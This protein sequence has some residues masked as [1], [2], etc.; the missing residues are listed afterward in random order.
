MRGRFQRLPRM[1]VI[2]FPVV[3]A[4][5]IATGALQLE[6]L[7]R[8]DAFVYD[9]R[10]RIFMPRTLDER[11]VIVDLDEK[12]LAE[13]G[14]WPWSRNVM[15]RLVDTLFD[16]QKIAALA[17]DVVFAEADESSGLGKLQKLARDELRLQQGFKQ[18][19]QRL[20]PALDY[21]RLFAEALRGRPVVLGYYFTSDREGRKSGLLPEPVF[22]DADLQ[23]RRFEVTEWDGYGANIE[24]LA[25][26]APG[27]GFFNPVIDSDGVVRS[28]PLLARYDG[29]YYESM[30]L[31]LFRT[32]LGNAVVKPG[33]A[34]AG[35]YQHL[36]SVRLER[37]DDSFEIP[38]DRQ[39]AAWVPF[40][41]PAGPEGGSFTYISAVDLLSGSLPPGMLQGK[42]VFLGTTAPGLLDLRVTPVSKTYPGVEVQANLLSGLLDGQMPVEPDYAQGYNLLQIVFCGL[43]LVGLLPRLGALM[44]I[45][46]SLGLG[47]TLVGLNFWLYAAAGLVFPLATA[48]LMIALAFALNMSYG[49]FVEG[50]SKRSLAHLFGAYVPPE[51]V[52]EMVKDPSRY[53]MQAEEKTLTVMFSDMRGFTK[54]SETMAP[55]QL[56]QLLN[57]VFDRLTHEIRRH[58]G[59]IDKYMGDCVMAFWGAPVDMPNHARLAVAAALD[60]RQA[61]TEVN[62]KIVAQGLPPIGMG[63]GLNTGPMCVGDMGS[64]QRRSYTVIG[65]AVN[66]GSRLEGLSKFYGVDIVVSGQ[67]RAQAGNDFIWQELDL[68]KVKG[69]NEAVPIHTVWGEQGKQAPSLALE[70]DQ[71]ADFLKLW[72]GQQWDAALSAVQDLAGRFP[73]KVLYHVYL[74][75]VMAR[76]GAMFDPAWDG[77]M[78]FE[79]K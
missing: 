58:K 35:D 48:V 9:A 30:A 21:D 26:A 56:Q 20:T 2:L 62:A 10:L 36:A 70:L 6:I 51:L 75:R 8:L 23:G 42:V 57:D 22:D 40:R 16:E 45:A 11:I 27:A 47:A 5:A 71:W 53:G 7:Q 15:A 29:K 67:T 66:L 78:Q 73:E 38:V 17:I 61:V 3:L 46:L 72:R 64:R 1:L 59:T 12:S 34:D 76:Q 55:T 32:L 69:K 19:L 68:V 52:D 13:V 49:Y 33:F 50:R 31:A 54:L 28:L 44:A 74:A 25:S 43:L 79:S 37:Q 18:A 39:V 4:V 60:M 24:R 77:S 65:D 14:R 63:I 41:G